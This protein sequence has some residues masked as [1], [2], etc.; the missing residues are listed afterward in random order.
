ML[1]LTSIDKTAQKLS[2]RYM[3]QKGFAQ[4]VLLILLMIGVGI[5]AYLVQNQ[6]IFTSKAVSIKSFDYST[7]TL[8]SDYFKNDDTAVK[9]AQGQIINYRFSDLYTGISDPSQL[10][11]NKFQYKILSSLRMLGY[12]Y[13]QMQF[14]QVLTKWAFHFQ[15]HNFISTSD[16]I[17]ND[18]MIA[19]DKAIYAQE[20]QENLYTGYFPLNENYLIG[21]QTVT[22][23][24]AH[25]NEPSKN[26]VRFFMSYLLSAIP[27]KEA[28]LNIDYLSTFLENNG[29][30]MIYIDNGK[31]LNYIPSAMPLNKLQAGIYKST[32]LQRSDIPASAALLREYGYYLDNLGTLNPNAVSLN[33]GAFYQL[34]YNTNDCQIHPVNQKSCRL[35]EAAK[36]VTTNAKGIPDQNYPGYYFTKTAFAE[37]FATYI[38]EGKLYKKLSNIDQ[39][40]KLQYEWL[41]KNIFEDKEYDTGDES[42]VKSN[43]P[44]WDYSQ[45]K[46]PSAIANLIA[47]TL[48]NRLDE[49]HPVFTLTDLI[50]ST[51][52]EVVAPPTPT[53]LQSKPTPTNPP[54]PTVTPIPMPTSTPKPT[55]TPTPTPQLTPTPAPTRVP[56]PTTTP[57]PAPFVCTPCK[58]DIIVNGIVDGIDYGNIYYCLNKKTTDK[59]IYGNSCASADIDG[60][61]SINST[62]FSCVQSK[63]FQRCYR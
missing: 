56:N 36:F 61:G 53:P 45:N 48:A 21:D 26:H 55:A 52:R 49:G 51:P 1:S 9:I 16:L 5:G 32:R 41:K 33:T 22:Y 54:L 6:Q 58:A 40:Y 18:F 28:P 23:V 10:D 13:D 59:N 30:G 14:N 37:S 60:N 27:K 11:S 43:N 25:Q 17:S 2:N 44:Y 19:L 29:Q 50:Q 62:D 12:T 42:L 57:T 20:Q 39:N 3:A 47:A 38:L 31:K 15:N 63:L 35:K 7:V 46:T 4:I 8:K 34:L 24:P